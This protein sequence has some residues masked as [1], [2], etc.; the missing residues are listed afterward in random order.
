M[1]IDVIHYFRSMSFFLGAAVDLTAEEPGRTLYKCWVFGPKMVENAVIVICGVH[2]CV[3][4]LV[5]LPRLVLFFITYYDLY[6]FYY[7][8][9]SIV[10]R[11][12]EDRQKSCHQTRES[13][14]I[15]RHTVKASDQGLLYR[16]GYRL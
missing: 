1:P 15:W 4:I 12:W 16:M 5:F 6:L 2:V 11:D 13:L 3:P 10:K 9:D 7:G 14:R 8:Y